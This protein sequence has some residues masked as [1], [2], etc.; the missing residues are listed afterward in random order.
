MRQFLFCFLLLIAMLLGCDRGS[1]RLAQADAQR[2]AAKYS[3]RGTFDHLRDCCTRRA[4]WAMRPY[5]DPPHCEEV[6][7]LLIAVDELLAANAGTQHAIHVSCP[8]FPADKLDLSALADNLEL[9]SRTVL[10]VSLEESESKGI[11]H[12]RI[13]DRTELTDLSFENRGGYWVYMPGSNPAD[14]V[15]VIRDMKTALD[16]ITV[17]LDDTPKTPEQIGNEYR[18]RIGPKLKRINQLAGNS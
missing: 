7:D 13:G 14:L 16:R 18:L 2:G 10:F 9:F 6:L 11:V 8:S 4:Y 5:I 3:L 15:Q 12:V 1:P 17:A